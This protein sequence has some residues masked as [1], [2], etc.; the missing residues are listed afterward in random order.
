MAAVAFRWAKGIGH[1]QGLGV[2]WNLAL[3]AQALANGSPAQ[4]DGNL[5]I[6]TVE[7]WI[8]KKLEIQNKTNK[9]KTQDL[10]PAHAG[11][12]LIY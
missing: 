11:N 9:Q 4:S 2:K 1:K 3:I 6:K 12:K 8:P 7:G 5:L 10:V